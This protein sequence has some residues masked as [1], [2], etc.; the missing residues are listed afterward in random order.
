MSIIEPEGKTVT[1]SFRLDK[2][3]HD[4]LAEIAEERGVSLSSL[5]EKVCR[6]YVLFYQWVENLGSIIFSPNTVLE[7]INTLDEKQLRE[8]AEK[9][10]KSTFKESYMVRGDNLDFETVRFQIK[11]QM[12]RYANWFT[13][14]EHETDDHYFYIQHNYGEKWSFFVETYLSSLFRSIAEV[15]VE[16]ERVDHNILVKIRTGKN[17]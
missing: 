13:V 9:V 14:I 7:I 11:D 4:S 16:T 8:I 2:A 10:A 15:D 17:N 5:L 3:W 12:G 1:R 6:D